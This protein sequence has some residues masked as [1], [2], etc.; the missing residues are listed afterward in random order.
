M[1]RGMQTHLAFYVK[2]L[3]NA[4]EQWTKLLA[5]LDPEIVKRKPVILES[6]EG[7][8]SPAPRLS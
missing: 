2:D 7:T 6:G 4:L 8:C 5:I 3:D 1:P